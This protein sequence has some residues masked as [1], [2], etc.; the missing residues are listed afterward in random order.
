MMNDKSNAAV[1]PSSLAPQERKRTIVAL[2]SASIISLVVWGLI[3]A[4]KIQ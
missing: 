2:V 3:L 4:L 1:M